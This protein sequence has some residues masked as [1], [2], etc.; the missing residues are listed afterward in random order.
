MLLFRILLPLIAFAEK[1]PI[2]ET[3][4]S[5]HNMAV[6]SFELK[7][8][9]VD[10][11]RVF[12][13]QG[14]ERPFNLSRLSFEQIIYVIDGDCAD[15]VSWATQIDE[16]KIVIVK[17]FPIKLMSRY[18]RVFCVDYGATI[19]MFFNIKNLPACIYIKDK[20]CF[21]QEGVFAINGQEHTI[22]KTQ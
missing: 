9:Y 2:V 17:G 1:F 12:G 15:Q 8:F 18:K 21:I 3:G 7:S 20:K 5:A 11:K 10:I 14:V 22:H 4:F 16:A 13:S 19:T 6:P